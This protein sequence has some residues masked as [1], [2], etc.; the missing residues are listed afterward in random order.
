MVDWNKDIKLGRKRGDKPEQQKADAPARPAA[1]KPSVWKKE[2]RPGRKKDAAP[3]ARPSPAPE[4]VRPW[5]GRA[6]R[7]VVGS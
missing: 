1:E 7:R 6:W 5:W 2:L 3:A 4:P